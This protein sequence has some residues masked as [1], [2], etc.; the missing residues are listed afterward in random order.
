MSALPPYSGDK[1]YCFKCGNDA[2]HT[3]HR[4][5]ITGTDLDRFSCHG[6]PMQAEYL[7]RECVRCGFRWAEECI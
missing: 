3:K 2:A 7:E 4:A 5:T 6:A 1:T